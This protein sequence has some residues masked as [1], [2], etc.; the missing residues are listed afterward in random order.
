MAESRFIFCTARLSGT[1]TFINLISLLATGQASREARL[2]FLR[3]NNP[4]INMKK[5]ILFL[6]AAVLSV[7]SASAQQWSVGTNLLGYGNMGTLNMEASAAV[8]RHFTVNTT[9]EVNPWT[10]NAGDPETQKQNRSQSYAVGMRWWPWHVYS[11]WWTAGRL[12]YSEYNRG[13]FISRL[14]EE[15][16]AYG[17]GI[18]AGYALMLRDNLNL[19]AGAGFWGGYRTYTVYPCPVCGK[20]TG[21]GAKWFVRPSEAILSL[22]FIF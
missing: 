1:G 19:E 13:G 8:A 9:I 2:S 14:T 15:G 12:R 5:S 10:F 20:A 11:G 17:A 22:V 7:F 6:A 4:L 16:D 18:S 21:S 3:E